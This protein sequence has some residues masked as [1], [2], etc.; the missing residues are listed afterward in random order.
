[1]ILANETNLDGRTALVTG[2]SSGIGR[3]IAIALGQAGVRVALCARRRARLEEV[4]ETILFLVSD[5]SSYITGQAIVVD[6]GE[7]I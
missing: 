6:G 2:A 3:A 1:M 4:A 7:T 5:R